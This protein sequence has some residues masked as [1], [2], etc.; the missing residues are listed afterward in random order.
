MV[1]KLNKM[2]RE[3]AENKLT[4]NFSVITRL[5]FGKQ[6]HRE[7]FRNT[8][9]NCQGMKDRNRWRSNYTLNHIFYT[10]KY[11]FILLFLVS[12]F[13]N[14]SL[15]AFGQRDNFEEWVEDFERYTTEQNINESEEK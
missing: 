15:S 13:F 2:L 6:I 7:S 12:F 3:K 14:C 4:Q 8:A 9:I 1:K 10:V 11:S 5:V